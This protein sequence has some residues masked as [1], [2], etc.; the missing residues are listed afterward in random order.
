MKIA[1]SKIQIQGSLEAVWHKLVDWQTMH[2]WD[3]FMESVIF[4]GPLRLGSK[5]KLRMKGG[6]EVELVVTSFNEPHSYTDEFTLLGS[7]F[8]FFHQLS[9]HSENLLVLHITVE[10]NGFLASLLA[11]LMRIDTEKKMPILMNNF[12]KQFETNKASA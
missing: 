1:D 2:T 3:I 8:I 12:K 5:G 11:P 10:T 7:R 6:P 4:D 9:E